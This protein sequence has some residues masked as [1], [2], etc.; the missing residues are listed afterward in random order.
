MELICPDCGRKFLFELFLIDM[1][2]ESIKINPKL[3][4]ICGNC[5]LKTE[6]WKNF[7]KEISKQNAR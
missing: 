7:I 1:L 4:I 2:K 5:G 6:G 3:K